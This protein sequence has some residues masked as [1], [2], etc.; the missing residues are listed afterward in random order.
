MNNSWEVYTKINPSCPNPID[1]WLVCFIEVTQMKLE[2]M[3]ALSFLRTEQL[4]SFIIVCLWYGHKELY[5]CHIFLHVVPGL[6]VMPVWILL[7]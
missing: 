5:V 4:Y 7:Q 2:E 1:F 3:R 6:H